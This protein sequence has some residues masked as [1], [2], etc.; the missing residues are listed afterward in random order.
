MEA[1]W[2]ISMRDEE[3]F[4]VVNKLNRFAVGD[5]DPLTFNADGSLDIYIQSES[6]GADKEPNWLPGPAKGKLAVTMRLYSP[7]AQVVDGRWAPPAAKRVN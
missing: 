5:H 7:K 4:Q 6:P 3:G 2:S 1:L